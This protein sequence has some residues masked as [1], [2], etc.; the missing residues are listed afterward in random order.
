M[1]GQQNIK[2]NFKDVKSSAVYINNNL[3]RKRGRDGS[4]GIFSRLLDGRSKSCIRFQGTSSP[5]IM[6]PVHKAEHPPLSSTAEVRNAYSLM[7][8]LPSLCG[9]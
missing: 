3:F 5:G 7:H 6:W 9:A 8:C 2:T 1:R 4:V